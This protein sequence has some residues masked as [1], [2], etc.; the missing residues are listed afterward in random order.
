MGQPKTK[1]IGG[2]GAV[3]TAN[4]FNKMLLDYLS[5]GSGNSPAGGGGIGEA[6]RQTNAFRGAMD[7]QLAGVGADQGQF[8]QYFRGV[9]AGNPGGAQAQDYSYT[10]HDLLN[11]DLNSPEFNALR[12]MQ[13]RQSQADLAN[14]S[15]KFSSMGAGGR[16]TGAAY[17]QGNYLAEANPRNILAQGDLMRQIQGMDLS[18]YQA[19]N[20]NRQALL[21]L[22]QNQNQ[23]D[24]AWAGMQAQTGLGLNNQSMQGI[25]QML[26]Q[27]FGG[28]QQSN[29]LG[30]AQ[31]QTIQVPNGYQQTIG[32]INDALGIVKGITSIA[33]PFSGGAK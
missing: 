2:G 1:Q 26:A 22:G 32:G 29:G 10:P 11:V 24:Q 18:N 8:A 13:N 5:N 33:N 7:N 17:A 20:Q 6:G 19:N 30:T 28:M 23:L 25:Q 12:T 27:L 31:R 16:G 3:D 9:Q 15:A 4:Q 14:L 21:G